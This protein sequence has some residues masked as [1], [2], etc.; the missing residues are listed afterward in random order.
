MAPANARRVLRFAVRTAVLIVLAGAVGV[1]VTL[2]ASAPSFNSPQS[3][4]P[5]LA[6]APGASPT[7]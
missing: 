2:A 6:A 4:L 1:L 3:A 7:P 5:Q